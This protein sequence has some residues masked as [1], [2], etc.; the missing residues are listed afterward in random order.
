MARVKS[1]PAGT[2]MLREI[3]FC[4]NRDAMTSNLQI[5]DEPMR[6]TS[7]VLQIKGSTLHRC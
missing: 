3:P 2:D 5:T 6:L 7:G 4:N 1:N